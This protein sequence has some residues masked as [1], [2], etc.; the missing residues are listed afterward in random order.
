[1]AAPFPPDSVGLVT[2]QKAHFD[3]TLAQD[4]GR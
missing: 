2:P 3:V 1:M 4:C